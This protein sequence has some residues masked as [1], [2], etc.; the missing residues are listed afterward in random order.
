MQLSY[1]LNNWQN[2]FGTKVAKVLK[3]Y[4]EVD[5]AEFFNDHQVIMD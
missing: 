5:Q 4:I 3:R 2:E 1:C